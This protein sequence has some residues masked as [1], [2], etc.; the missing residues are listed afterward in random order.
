MA[1]GAGAGLAE[2]AGCNPEEF[3]GHPT[4]VLPYLTLKRH[5]Q[6]PRHM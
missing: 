1:E 2:G 5:L 6:G 4:L 3:L